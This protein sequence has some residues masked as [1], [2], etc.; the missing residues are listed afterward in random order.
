MGC[1][2]SQSSAVIPYVELGTAE[3]RRAAQMSSPIQEWLASIAPVGSSMRPDQA[4][5]VN[6][7]QRDGMPMNYPLHYAAMI[8]DVDA[9]TNI[10]QGGAV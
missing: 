9:I 4:E 7:L 10:L 2:P 8:G 5:A 1:G 3:M 6:A